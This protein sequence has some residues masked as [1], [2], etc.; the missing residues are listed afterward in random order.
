M[1]VV[2]C[3]QFHDRQTGP[4]LV[5]HSAAIGADEL[6]HAGQ[7]ALG[8]GLEIVG[9]AA[10]IEACDRHLHEELQRIPARAV[11]LQF[12][13]SLVEVTQF[14]P[15]RRHEAI[16]DPA[17]AA[18]ERF[19]IHPLLPTQPD[20]IRMCDAP[21]SIRDVSMSLMLNSPCLVNLHSGAPRNLSS[22]VLISIHGL[23]ASPVKAFAVFLTIA[24]FPRWASACL[25]WS[26]NTSSV[27]G[28]F[29]LALMVTFSISALPDESAGALFAQRANFVDCCLL[30]VVKLVPQD[31]SDFGMHFVTAKGM[32]VQEVT[33]GSAENLP[34]LR[35]HYMC[36]VLRVKHNP[37][38]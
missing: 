29:F 20:F 17:D 4:L 1:P 34:D 11:I 22:S 18:V 13:L 33:Q 38:C 9:F 28:I 5:L 2:V 30:D 26:F 21:R 16:S 27:V 12:P 31:C 36:A 25:C 19:S 10:C 6:A 14:A 8:P 7:S 37:R 24:V 15:R 35:S 32:A 3:P 23:L